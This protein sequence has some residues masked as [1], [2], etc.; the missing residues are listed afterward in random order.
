MKWFHSSLRSPEGRIAAGT[1]AALLLI[2]ILRVVWLDVHY[3]QV[4]VPLETVLGG[5][6]ENLTS[7][8]REGDKLIADT[9][10]PQILFALDEP[11]RI[12]EIQFDIG[13]ISRMNCRW[14]IDL[15]D[16]W[17]QGDTIMKEGRNYVTFEDSGTDTRLIQMTPVTLRGVSFELQSFTIN[18]HSHFLF[19]TFRAVLLLAAVF[20]LLEFI[21]FTMMRRF[22]ENGEKHFGIVFVLLTGLQIFLD[23]FFVILYY[24]AEWEGYE[25][26]YYFLMVFAESGFVLL[27]QIPDAHKRELPALRI[28]LLTLF[29][30]GLV[31]TD[32]GDTFQL[33]KGIAVFGNL[34]IY[35]FPYCVFWSACGNHLRRFTYT[36]PTAL[37]LFIG[38]VNHYYFEFR[39]QALEFADISMARTAA[40]VMGQYHLDVTQQVLYVYVGSALLFAAAST[41]SI[42]AFRRKSLK[43]RIPALIPA[44]FTLFW[45]PLEKPYVSLWNT[46]TATKYNGYALSFFSYMEKALEKPTPAGYSAK[47][48]GELLSRYMTAGS[49]DAGGRGTPAAAEGTGSTG[50]PEAQSGGAVNVIVLM[51]EAFADLPATYGFETDVD[52]LPF[53]HSLSGSNVRKGWMLSSVFGGTTA[54]TEYEFLTGNSTAFLNAESVPYTQYLNSE[55]ESLAWL[56]KERGFYAQAF[57][58]YYESGYKRYQVYPLLGFDDFHSLEDGLKYSEKLRSYVSDAADFCDVIDIYENKAPGQKLFLFNVT[59]QNHGSYNTDTP[60]VDVTVRPTD[61]DYQLP[62]LLEYLALAH[63][64]DA[65]FGELVDYFEDVEEKTV[66]LLFGDHQPGMLDSTYEV[67]APKMYEDGADVAEREKKYTVPYVLWANYDLKSDPADVISPGFL[68]SYLLENAGIEG[69]AYDRYLQEVRKSVPAVNILGFADED[70]VLHD[71]TE[72]GGNETLVDYRKAAYYNLFDHSHV[73]KEFFN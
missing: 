60:A 38:M 53:I 4:D 16:S 64:T 48:T 35:A 17:Q 3:P 28:I 51:D 34:L 24:T 22:F 71:I 68:R 14:Y 58:P 61:P 5:E 1:I 41:E 25:I 55:Q 54:N 19:V 30:F 12:R 69:S 37:W 66:I 57:H 42:R 70:G 8:S 13:S 7:L 46:N 33:G 39:S 11:V 23:L 59:M 43:S 65:A 73:K 6:D 29:V 56:L 36:L 32:Y 18:P 72:L 31:E 49:G 67:F 20:V 15:T 27:T 9:N 21:L 63:A 52:E 10:R 50:T 45:V 62:Q 40:N 47:E 44:V 26:A 2:G